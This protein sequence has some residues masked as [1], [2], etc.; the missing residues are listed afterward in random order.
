M[1]SRVQHLE[2]LLSGG[3]FPERG[4]GG[5]VAVAIAGLTSFLS[6][7]SRHCFPNGP[8]FHRGWRK[9]V[10][11]TPEELPSFH[12][13]GQ[14]PSS[15]HRL[16]RSFRRRLIDWRYRLQPRPLRGRS[17]TFTG[18]CCQPFCPGD[19]TSHSDGPR[20]VPKYRREE[21][22]ISPSRLHQ[23][24]EIGPPSEPKRDASRTIFTW[25]LRRRSLSP[26]AGCIPQQS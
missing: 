23:V 15:F 26:D 25:P 17:R 22:R 13:R 18:Q 19:P 10:P 5:P 3:G 11:T 14:A 16:R 7:L 1:T 8:S 20:V 9:P 24:R 2:A 6:G 12:E 4:T 21:G